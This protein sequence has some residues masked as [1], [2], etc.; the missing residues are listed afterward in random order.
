[1]DSQRVKEIIESHGVINVLYQNN[2]VW[3]EAVKDLNHAQVVNLN[4]NERMDVAVT[5]LVED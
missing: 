3:I 2:P 4:S 5:E 1:M